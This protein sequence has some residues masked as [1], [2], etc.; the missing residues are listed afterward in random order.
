MSVLVDEATRVIVQGATGYQGRH[1]VRAIQEFGGTVVAGVTPGRGGG[2]VH[3]VPVYDTV[4]ESLSHGPNASLV[5]VPA[6]HTR[7]AVYEA[8]D[9]GIELVVVVTD[10]VPVNDAMDMVQYARCH[11]A[12][13][14]GPNCPGFV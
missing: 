7:D 2:M 14:I 12:T 13:L 11:S 3:D 4:R 8:V 1:H 10:G 6:L 5:L 9:G